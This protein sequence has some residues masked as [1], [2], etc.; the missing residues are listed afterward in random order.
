MKDKV[1]LKY[2]KRKWELDDDLIYKKAGINQ[3]GFVSGEICGNLL[4]VHG[5]V[6]ST[7]CSKSCKLPVYYIKMRNGIKLIMRNNFYDWKM[8]VEIPEQ[9]AA[10]PI[11]FLPADCLSHSMVKNE[12][13][14][15]ATCYM[16]GFS[17]EWCY[18]AY[19]PKNPPKRFSIEVPDNHRLYVIIHRLKHAYPDVEFHTEDD[20]RTKEHIAEAIERIWNANGFADLRD[21]ERWG[22][23]FKKPVMSGWEILWQTYRKIDDLYYDHKIDVKELPDL[24][25]S[26]PM[27]F[28]ELIMQHP[29]VHEEFLRE[30]WMFE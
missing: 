29:E 17:S 10:L 1:E 24:S 22:T 16:E 25:K 9:Y 14:K 30:E 3:A 21:E 11:D 23:T 15:I 19:L 2:W 7:H 20:T 28:A 27:Q 13:D 6:V 12:G 18:D 26:K 8:S 5:F 4:H